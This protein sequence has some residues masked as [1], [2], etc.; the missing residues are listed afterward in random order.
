MAPVGFAIH[1][2]LGLLRNS[3]KIHNIQFEEQ[4]CSA[5]SGR[6]LDVTK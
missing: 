1:V 3:Y 6:K 5:R 4:G 2:E